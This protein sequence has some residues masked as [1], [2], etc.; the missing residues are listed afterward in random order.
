[1]ARKL[2]YRNNNFR[3]TV[4]EYVFLVVAFVLVCRLFQIQVLHH[5]KYKVLAQEQYWDFAVIPARR[6]D[7]LSSD[8]YPLATTQVSYLLFV[9]PKRLAPR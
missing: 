7:I 8:G 1:M 5:E 2:N 9:E 6:G 4:V 3:I